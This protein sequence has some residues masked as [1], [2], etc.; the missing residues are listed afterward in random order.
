MKGNKKHDEDR[1]AEEREVRI[2]DL[3]A[4]RISSFGTGNL[5][6]LCVEDNTCGFSSTVKLAAYSYLWQLHALTLAFRNPC[7]L[8]H[9]I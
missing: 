8:L 5:S 9:C 7:L 2:A 1:H 4:G 3:K 6:V